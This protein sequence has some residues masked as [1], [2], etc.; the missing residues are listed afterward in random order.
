M[1]DDRLGAA[2]GSWLRAIDRPPRDS[3][4]SVEAVMTQV[5]TV[6]QVRRWWPLAGL[7]R[8][9]EA[10]T[11]S[12]TIGYQAHLIPAT[13]GHTPTVSGRTHLMF[14]PVKAITA[15]ALMLALGGV[16]LVA[17]PFQRERLVPGA[18][19]GPAAAFVTGTITGHPTGIAERM[20]PPAGVGKRFHVTGETATIET[21]DARMTG[22]VTS[23][24]TL[25]GI[26]VAEIPPP[27]LGAELSWATVSIQTDDGRWEGRRTC[28]PTLATNG[29]E[30]P[31]FYQLQGRDAY[32]GLSAVLAVGKRLA[33][34][35]ASAEAQ[36]ETH[37]IDGLIFEG[38][39][40][41]DR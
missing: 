38:N 40:P 27:Y 11:V 7:A 17:Q 36:D 33:G 25:D 20:T 39:L 3:R 9:P 2:A 22:E 35:P 28:V 4:A 8:R 24:A 29:V 34:D 5:R 18:E 26:P 12:D 19:T 30:D 23:E 21:S 37:Q 14:S 6:R 1:T 32:E 31:C 41:P 15:A 10:P 16:M 13:N